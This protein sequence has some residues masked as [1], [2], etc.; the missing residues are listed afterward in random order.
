MLV[1]KEMCLL[2]H[3][4]AAALETWRGVG[5]ADWATFPLAASKR[6]PSVGIITDS[7]HTQ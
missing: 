3:R 7:E 1:M 2:P 4:T 5:M 6:N